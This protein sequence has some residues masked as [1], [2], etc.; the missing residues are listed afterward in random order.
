MSDVAQLAR[1]ERHV[2]LL[3]IY[4]AASS[5]AVVVGCLT[6]FTRAQPGT[7]QKFQE[8]DVERINLVERDGRLRLA[9]T[10]R[11][12]SPGPVFKGKPFGY[13]GG[14][15]AGMIFYDDEG[16]ENGGLT[17]RGRRD[18]TGQ[19][20]AAGHLSFDQYGQDQVINLEYEEGKGR[21]QQGLTIA[22]RPE[23]ALVDVVAR[24]DS[25]RR[26]PDGPA[27]DSA[28]R[29]WV[30]WQGGA[31]YGAPRLFVGRDQQRA[32]VVDLRDPA[33]RSRL[34]LTVDSLGGA[35]IDFLDD[36]GHVVRRVGGTSSDD[37]LPTRRR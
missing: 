19:P 34:R 28:R 2:R 10:N 32:A 8:I 33:G 22:D 23:P 7:H 5:V 17:F 27:K 14:T 13:A 36:S 6:A 3:R 18:S 12:R 1:L 4:A 11:E 37:A 20:S 25:I 9:I 26:M 31:A 16:T 24:Q 30:Q 21:R 29:A 15:R 35:H